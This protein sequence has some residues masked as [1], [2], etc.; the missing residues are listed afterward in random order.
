MKLVAQR[1]VQPG[2]GPSRRSGVNAYCSLHGD[3]YWLDAPPDD[4]GRG[5]LV[6]QILEVSP[7]VGNRVR[8]YLEVTA[9]D[10]TSSKQIAFAV[11]DGAALLASGERPLPWRLSHGEVSFA[12]DLEE[13]LA[14]DWQL[15]LSLLLRYALAVRV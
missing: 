10:S 15:E 13:A 11:A 4:L 1:V 7:P 12:F 5:A 6:N 9:P 3:I 8:S 14:A 2:E